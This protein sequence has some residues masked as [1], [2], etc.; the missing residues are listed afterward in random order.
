MQLISA[1]SIPFATTTMFFLKGLPITN[2]GMEES[3]IQDWPHH[4]KAKITG[5][6][7]RTEFQKDELAQ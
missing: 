7:E 5:T 3:I 6:P 4:G 2:N 1:Q